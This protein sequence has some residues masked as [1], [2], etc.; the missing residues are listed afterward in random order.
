VPDYGH[1]M[2]EDLGPATPYHAPLY[3]AL[4][5]TFEGVR[6]VKLAV[7]ADLDAVRAALPNPLSRST[8]PF[9]AL[10]VHEVPDGPFGPFRMACQNIVCRYTT[11]VR[12]FVLQ[13]VIDNPV[14]LAAFREV[15]SIPAKPGIVELS[16]AGGDGSRSG[17]V[18][19]AAGALL[20]AWELSNIEGAEAERV[21]LEP[22][23]TLR[24]QPEYA[25]QAE[26]EPPRLIQV[27]R[28]Y[29]LRDPHRGRV[30]LSFHD[31]GRDY[32]WA[33]LPIT[34]P[35]VG[36]DTGAD[37]HYDRTEYVLDYERQLEPIE[38]PG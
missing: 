28:A 17:R 10:V 6:V 27:N 7:E 16:A 13:A 36:V 37:L 32:P 18:L 21:L 1:V 15:W 29:A 5:W 9:A 24:L 38:V 14:A 35:I 19:S 11:F 4:P 22:E 31:G 30:S 20:A 33:V 3:P 25:V 23:I 8:P 2:L 34:H 12:A 26:A